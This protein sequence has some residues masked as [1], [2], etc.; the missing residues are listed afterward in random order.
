MKREEREE[1]KKGNKKIVNGERTRRRRKFIL[2]LFM[3]VVEYLFVNVVKT[4]LHSPYT[5]FLPLSLSLIRSK[6]YVYI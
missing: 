5:H 2:N 3:G 1:R 6:V 4:S